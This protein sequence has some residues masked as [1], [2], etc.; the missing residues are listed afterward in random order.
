MKLTSS[1][2]ET[3]T[4]SVPA[5]VCTTDGF[6][7]KKKA[8]TWQNLPDLPHTDARAPGREQCTAFSVLKKKLTNAMKLAHFDDKEAPTKVIADA[9]PVGLGAVLVQEQSQ[10]PVVVS[11]ASRSLS[12]VERRYSQTEKEA[13]GLVWACEKFHPYIYGQCFELLTDHTPLEAIYAPKSKPCARI[14]RWVLRLQPYEFKVIHLPGKNNI[15]DPLSRLL[16]VDMTQQSEFSK[17]A[18]EHVRFVA[19]NS[20]PKAMTTHDVERASSDDAELQQLRECID[21]GRWTDCPDKLYAA[22]SGELCVIGQLVL[23]GSRIVMPRKLRPQALALAH[24]GHLG[25]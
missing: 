5:H 9:S 18:E 11:Y 6:P 8:Q 7:M 19:I 4:R 16:K 12:D 20:T 22:I 10:G 24:E 25:E 15:A 17:M 21:T 2:T 14:E 3:S 23:R 13:L 1:C